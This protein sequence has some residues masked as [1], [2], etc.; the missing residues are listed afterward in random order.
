ML[1]VLVRHVVN[2][3]A[4]VL[5]LAMLVGGLVGFRAAPGH[6]QCTQKVGC[7]VQ[8]LGSQCYQSFDG[9]GTTTVG[10]VITKGGVANS[11]WVSNA[12]CTVD[13]CSCSGDGVTVDVQQASGTP[14]CCAIQ[15]NAADVPVKT[16]SNPM[17]T[18]SKY[19]GCAGCTANSPG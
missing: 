13:K 18:I 12:G 10:L 4:F 6:A 15:T 17:G 8:C 11:W 19:T 2:R 9:L 5:L 1:T 14:Y 7:V 3:R 16:C